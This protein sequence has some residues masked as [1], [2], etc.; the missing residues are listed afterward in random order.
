MKAFQ[1][2]S[3]PPVFRF[4][5]SFPGTQSREGKW[6]SQSAAQNCLP[7]ALLDD[8]NG[9]DDADVVDVVDDD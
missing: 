4:A 5:N 3:L 2:K 6:R 8:N 1:A 9:G 7:G